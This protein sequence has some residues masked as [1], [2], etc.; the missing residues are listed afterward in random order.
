MEKLGLIL[1][2][3]HL[4]VKVVQENDSDA[5]NIAIASYSSVLKSSVLKKTSGV[6]AN[7]ASALALT[8]KESSL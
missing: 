5:M 4:S 8:S 1:T 3:A 2:R 6:N 7:L